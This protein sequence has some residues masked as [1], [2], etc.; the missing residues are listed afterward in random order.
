MGA[1]SR[2]GFI[3]DPRLAD[4]VLLPAP[5]RRSAARAR[6]GDVVTKV[7]HEMAK[8]KGIR[9]WELAFLDEHAADSVGLD[10]QQRRENISRNLVLDDVKTLELRRFLRRPG[11]CA[12]IVDDVCTTGS[13]SAQF[14]LALRARGVEV[15]AVLVLAAA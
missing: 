9:V 2:R 14:A 15:A 12:V 10:R 7:C 4:V 1:L 13:T 8:G 3:A 5:T 11:R 6:G